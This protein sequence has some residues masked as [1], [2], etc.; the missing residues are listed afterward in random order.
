L[1][2][3]KTTHKHANTKAQR[4]EGTKVTTP[5][6]KRTAKMMKDRQFL[7]DATHDLGR[8]QFLASSVAAFLAMGG[9]A[10]A[11]DPSTKAKRSRVQLD[12]D[13]IQYVD[14]QRLVVALMG[15]PQIRMNPN[16]AEFARSAMSDLATLPHDFLVILG[17]LVQ[18]NPQFYDEYESIIL[19][20]STRPVFSVAG[21]ADL[22]CGL[23]V[24][25]ERT[26][27]PLY[28][29]IY[30]RGIRFIFL[31]VT[32]VV[33]PKTHICSLGH[34]QLTWL[35]SQLAAD[36]EATTVIFHHAP[37][38]ETTWRSEDRESLPFPGSMYLHES[39][40][41][42]ELFRQYEN[43]KVYAHGHV[44]HA[45]GVKDEFGRG[46]YCLEDGVLHI[47]V[48]ATA[49]NR[50]SSFLVVEQNRIVTQVRDHV[51]GKW[52]KQYD[53]VLEAKTTLK[54]V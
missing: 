14:P 35:R 7:C 3:E 51:G 41:M 39:K 31:S 52:R 28:F 53:Y 42:R 20:K 16:S 22:N 9:P 2:V 18:N 13:G 46:E 33:G 17:D 27:M 11:E 19:D 44:H 8:R 25:Q 50:G 45:Y 48:G 32:A 37:V 43:I 47:S 29:S 49:N 26:G 30:R 12:E 54:G 40:Q 36:K 4:H 34:E 24:Y 5:T 23:E 1:T 6:I 10:L 21:N 38:F 15:D